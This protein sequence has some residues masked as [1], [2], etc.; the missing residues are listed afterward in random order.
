MQDSDGDFTYDWKRVLYIILIQYSFDRF[1]NGYMV[2]AELL[3]RGP[4]FCDSRRYDS[5][6]GALFDDYRARSCFDAISNEGF[7]C[8]DS[9]QVVYDSCALFFPPVSRSRCFADSR[10]CDSK[11]ECASLH[12]CCVQQSHT[13]KEITY[14]IEIRIIGR[15]SFRGNANKA[16]IVNRAQR[17]ALHYT[18]S[19]CIPRNRKAF[20]LGER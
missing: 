2:R 11:P 5:R 9:K 17:H 12:D 7:T 16:G 14:K 13:N 18:T 19:Y 15:L 6:R 10:R 4:R 20:F 8:R 1:F 3:C